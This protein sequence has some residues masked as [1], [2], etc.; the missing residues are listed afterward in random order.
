MS[1]RKLTFTE[2]V[3]D[4]QQ[5][6]NVPKNQKNKFGGY[7]YRSL[8]DILQAVKPLLK[9]HRLALYLTDEVKSVD[10]SYSW[11]GTKETKDT[12]FTEEKY[13]GMA[14]IEAKALIT[15]GSSETEALGQAGIEF[16]KKGMDLSQSFGAS[17]S[18]ARKYACNGL[19]GI[20]DNKDSDFTNTHGKGG[21]SKRT[22]KSS[23]D[24]KPKEKTSLNDKHKHWDRAKAL[25]EKQ[26]VDGVDKLLEVYNISDEVQ[27]QLKELIK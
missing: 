1:E 26:G 6:L 16:N 2:K 8:E 14:Y 17:S 25:V 18:Y 19:F 27:K 3:I 4:I 7:N 20:D 23:G 22:R 13:D 24:E 15:D 5:R 11:L 9:E 12:D 21:S 10:G